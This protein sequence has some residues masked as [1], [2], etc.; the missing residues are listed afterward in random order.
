MPSNSYLRTLIEL[1]EY[2]YSPSLDERR[3]IN[4][5]DTA[6]ISICTGAG[7]KWLKDAPIFTKDPRSGLVTTHHSPY[8][9]L[10][11]FSLQSVHLSLVA[12][13]C[14][15][16]VLQASAARDYLLVADLIHMRKTVDPG[17]SFENPS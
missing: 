6:Q 13:N 9:T 1:Y 17:P 12:Q 7:S 5:L 10:P 15:R 14:A 16:F 8:T 2:N 11:N 4:Q 3:H